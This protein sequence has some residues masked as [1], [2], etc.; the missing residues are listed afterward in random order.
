M[1]VLEIFFVSISLIVSSFIGSGKCDQDVKP[2]YC[3]KEC[4]KADWPNHKS[5][6]KPGMPCSVIDSA[7][8]TPNAQ[9]Y[10]GPTPKGAYRVPVNMPGGES[11]RMTSST[12]SPQEMKDMRD[13]IQTRGTGSATNSRSFQVDI[14]EL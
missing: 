5:F 8:L 13:G 6:C 9:S 11:F 3:S 1:R 14:F 10:S 7:P 4:Q 2:S 12:F